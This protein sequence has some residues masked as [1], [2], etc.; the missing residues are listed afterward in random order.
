MTRPR[1]EASRRR[2][3]LLVVIVAFSSPTAPNSQ[4]LKQI[5]QSSPE[6]SNFLDKF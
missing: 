2:R 5:T 4:L 1:Q 6:V 3:R